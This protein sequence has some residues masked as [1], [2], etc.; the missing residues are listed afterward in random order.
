MRTAPRPPAS[1]RKPTTNVRLSQ[2]SYNFNNSFYYLRI[3]FRSG[4]IAGQQEKVYG[5]SLIGTR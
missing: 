4:I 3:V 1:L 2:S 5:S